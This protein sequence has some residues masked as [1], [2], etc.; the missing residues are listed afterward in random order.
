[1]ITQ[2]MEPTSWYIPTLSFKWIYSC[3]LPFEFLLEVN[4]ANIFRKQ[5]F[6]WTA[7]LRNVDNKIRNLSY[8]HFLNKSLQRKTRNKKPWGNCLLILIL[9]ISARSSTKK[10]KEAA[11]L[12]CMVILKGS[13]QFRS[14]LSRNTCQDWG[15]NTRF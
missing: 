4:N 12:F 13:M 9:F 7:V 1:M 5:I 2:I 11:Y 10:V 8:K 14:F 15:K 6:E 3:G